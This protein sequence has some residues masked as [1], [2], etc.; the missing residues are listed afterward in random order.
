MWVCNGED[1][2]KE[3]E[4]ERLTKKEEENVSVWYVMKCIKRSKMEK[5]KHLARREKREENRS[6]MD[7]D[8]ARAV[9][10]VFE[11]IRYYEAGKRKCQFANP[12]CK[13]GVASSI[14]SSLPSPLRRSNFRGTT[15][16]LIPLFS[17]FRFPLP[18]LFS[19]VNFI[20]DSQKPES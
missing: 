2:E 12:G 3:E 19:L 17:S 18:P 9:W 11:V 7:R 5:C 20:K 14:R 13:L 8:R 16:S 10:W 1:E 4:R 15:C 6:W